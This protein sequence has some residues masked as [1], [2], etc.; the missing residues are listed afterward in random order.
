MIK[1]DT[2]KTETRFIS[3]IVDRALSY[4]PDC[5]SQTIFMDITACHANGCEL[6]LEELLAF[7]E[8]DFKHDICG[9]NRHIDRKNGQLKNCFL[10][11]CAA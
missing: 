7:P 9:I 6:K 8:F 2:S 1:F 3:K 5:D 11:R 10:P 4:F